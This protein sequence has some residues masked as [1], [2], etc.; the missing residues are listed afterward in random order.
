MAHIYSKKVWLLL[1]SLLLSASTFA[2][3]VLSGKVVDD[4]DKPVT[5][6]SVYLLN[7]IDGA[8]TDSVGNF[9]FSTDEKGQQTLVATELGHTEV[10]M[11]L[12]ITGSKESKLT[13]HLLPMSLV[14][15]MTK[16]ELSI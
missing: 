13:Q 3:V 14:N 7:T 8:T 4:K 6:A 5:G 16:G 12:N 11:P 2:Q 1:S 9:K 10:G 15:R